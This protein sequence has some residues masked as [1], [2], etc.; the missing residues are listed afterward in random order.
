MV[1]RPT[2]AMRSAK[3]RSVIERKPTENGMMAQAANNA[4]TPMSRVT[5][6]VASA[7]SKRQPM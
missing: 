5:G 1:V 7:G 4:T 3:R 6:P 2:Q